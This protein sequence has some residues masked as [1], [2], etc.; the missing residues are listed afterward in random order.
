MF[1]AAWSVTIMSVIAEGGLV[2]VAK[3]WHDSV[4]AAKE[5]L[6]LLN[7][8]ELICAASHARDRLTEVLGENLERSISLLSTDEYFTDYSNQS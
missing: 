6:I 8:V 5:A 4:D 1:P 2:Q 3:L 7:H